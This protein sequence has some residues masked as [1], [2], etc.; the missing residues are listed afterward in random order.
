MPAAGVAISGTSQPIARATRVR[1][2]NP[3]RRHSRAG[4]VGAAPGDSAR[5]SAAESSTASS[6][7]TQDDSGRG[8]RNRTSDRYVV[9]LSATSA[10]QRSQLVYSSP[11]TGTADVPAP[12]P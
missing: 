4:I 1:Q 10:A 8:E 12:N 2:S 11:R 9:W 6:A 3:P 7:V 5:Y